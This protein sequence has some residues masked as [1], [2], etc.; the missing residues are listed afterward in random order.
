V[1]ALWGTPSKIFEKTIDR[2]A[3]RCYYFIEKEME[4]DFWIFT[5]EADRG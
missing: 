1:V 4:E 5:K 2:S 3:L